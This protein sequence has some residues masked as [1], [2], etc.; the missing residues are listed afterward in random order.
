MSPSGQLPVTAIVTTYNGEQYL[1]LAL[2]SVLAQTRPPVR[3]IVVDDA[4]TDRTPELIAAYAARDP[5][6]E[7]I[8]FPENRGVSAARNAALV[9]AETPLVAFLDGDDIWKPEHLETVVPLVL[10]HPEVALGFSLVERFGAADG[11]WDADLPEGIVTDAFWPS[12]AHCVAQTSAVVAQR[13]MLLAEGGYAEDLRQCQDFDLYMRLARK[14]PFICTHAVTVR[15]RRHPES[16]SHKLFDCRRFEY[17]ARL[18]FLEAERVRAADD[19][20]YLARLEAAMTAAYE[21]RFTEA[22]YRRDARMLD[23]LPEL[24]SSVPDG[25]AVV[26]RWSRRRPLLPA[27]RAWDRIPPAVRRRLRWAVRSLVP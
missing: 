6:F 22:W 2:D 17:R 12:V 11:V 21:E 7:I 26:A 27:A 14:H 19:P 4:S 9:A 25:D 16:N 20:D 13:E 5:R 15:Y 23:F 18:R 24:A 10:E 8:R 1:A 3:I